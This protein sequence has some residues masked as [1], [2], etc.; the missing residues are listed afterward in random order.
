MPF[1]F[2]NTR[3]TFMHVMM[4]VLRPFIGKFLVAYFDDI[5]IYNSTKEQH[6]NH[7]W[8]AC[9][10]LRKDQS[11]VNLKKCTFMSN[12]V[13]FLGFVV[14]AAGISAD[15]EKVQATVE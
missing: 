12:K 7:L 2:S 13:V 6:L 9:S 3:G 1:S 5:P 11:Y 4:Q 15:P 8:Q 10:T 14:S